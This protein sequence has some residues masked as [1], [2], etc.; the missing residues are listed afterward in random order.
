[1]VLWVILSVLSSFFDGT[2]LAVSKKILHGSDEYVVVTISRLFMIPFFLG[3]LLFVPLPQI[4]LT[5]WIASAIVIV[6]AIVANILQLTALKSSP[7]SLAAPF[8]T[9]TPI[10][11]LL[12]SPFI[13]KENP[14][15]LG[16]FG[17]LLGVVGAYVL[18]ISKFKEGFFE[19][20]KAIFKEKGCW[21]MLITAFLFAITSTFD[22]VGIKNSDPIFYLI[23]T[24]LALGI[25]NIPIMMW[26]SK[27]YKTKVKKDWKALFFIGLLSVATL[28][29]QFFA[30]KMA[31][32]PYVMSI[33]RMSII[34]G[35]LYGAFLFKEE[36]IKERL[37]GSII[38]VIS[39]VLISIA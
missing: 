22:K 30:V 25:F 23:I 13:L 11:L 33:K 27:D 7:I 29:S 6:V 17:V 21:I 12:F 14:S 34:F 18:N 31:L 26:K 16:I 5:F 1:M 28:V 35:V 8:L 39:V 2:R 15:A 38:M 3:W 9:F 10:F 19:P 37:I 36:K 32:V 24:Q 4:N 20:V